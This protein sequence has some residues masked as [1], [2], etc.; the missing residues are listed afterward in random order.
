[1]GQKIEL[2]KAHTVGTGIV[3]KPQTINE[4]INLL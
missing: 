4:R 3:S 2:G 1:M